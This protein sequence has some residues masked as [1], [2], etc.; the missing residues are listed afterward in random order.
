MR[1]FKINSLVIEVTRRCNMECAHCLRGDFETFYKFSMD[2]FSILP[3]IFEGI[4]SV[5]SIVI[6]GGEPTL[7]SDAIEKIVD[8]V[9]E[10]NLDVKGLYIVTNGLVYSQKMVDAMRRLYCYNIEKDYKGKLCDKNGSEENVW[11]ASFVKN[12]LFPE[13]MIPYGIAVSLDEFHD[14]IPAMNYMKY[15]ASGFYVPDKEVG[16]RRHPGDGII[17]RGRGGGIYRAEEMPDVDP[18]RLDDP[19][20]DRFDIIY[21]DLDGNVFGDCNLS[22]DMMEDIV[23]DYEKSSWESKTYLPYYNVNKDGSLG[24]ALERALKEQDE[25]E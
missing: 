2:D 5:D 6:G 1:K 19:D 23:D 14:H 9:I 18:I 20:D 16:E 4:E 25:D 3:R 17:A 22:Y 21:V 13:T 7:N 15:L 10:N 12:S 24:A 11:K 8:Y